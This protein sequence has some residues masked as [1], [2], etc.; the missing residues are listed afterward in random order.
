MPDR[1]TSA[2][3]VEKLYKEPRRVLEDPDL[4]T[5]DKISVLENWKSDLLQLQ[6]ASEESMQSPDARD[7]SIAERLKRVVE[8]LEELQLDADPER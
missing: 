4:T 5:E 6:R 2:R 1:K 3:D 7:G 8:A